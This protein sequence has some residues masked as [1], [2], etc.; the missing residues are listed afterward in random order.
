[1]GVGP[2]WWPHE[3]LREERRGIGGEAQ[4]ATSSRG[5]ASRLFSE[6]QRIHAPIRGGEQIIAMSES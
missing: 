1:M 2:K 3:A 6:P 4:K 5:G